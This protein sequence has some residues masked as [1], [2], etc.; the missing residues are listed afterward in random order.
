MEE[1]WKPVV[2]FEGLYE[3]SDLGRIR[4]LERTCVCGKAKRMPVKSRILKPIDHQR[5]YLVVRLH[6]LDG[7]SKQ[8]KIHRIVAATF[9]ENPLGLREV[10]HVNGN[11]HDNRAANLEWVSPSENMQ[12]AVNLGLKK[13]SRGEDAGSAKLTD[14]KVRE[15]R[16]LRPVRTYQEIA[17]L[18]GVTTMTAFNAIKGRTWA[19]VA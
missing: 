1:N 17:T 11:K 9:H 7:A 10:D 14:S 15:M 12:R 8:V 3:V 5:G 6:G 2:G 18:F 13:P 19:H 16:Q 4:S